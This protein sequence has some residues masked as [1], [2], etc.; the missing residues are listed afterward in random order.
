MG[1]MVDTEDFYDDYYK[2][3]HEEWE[4]PQVEKAKEAIMGELFNKFP[5]EVFY[6][7]QIQVLFENR[8]FHWI[9]SAALKE[10]V[11]EGVLIALKEVL[12]GPVSVMLYWSKG[13]RYWRR[14]ANRKID[15]IKEFSAPEFGRAL[16]K[17]AEMLFDASLPRFGFIPK[18]Q[19]VREYGDIRWEKTGHDLDRVF[20]RDGIAYGAEIKNKLT[21]IDKDELKIKIE[22]CGELKLKSL[23]IMRMA[24]KTYIHLINEA[25]GFALIF[26]YQLYPFGAE[27]LAKR[28]KEEMSHEGMNFPVDCPRAIESG[29]IQRFL[30]WHLKKNGLQ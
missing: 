28:V 25:G 3:G 16:G 11:N 27:A 9:T 20:E 10:L 7:R 24:P 13:N 8:F 22:M 29:T 6:G 18:G 14:K 2:G 5:E 23:F 4:D 30:N 1:K 12:L 21:Y 26:K 17:Q 19:D 15:I